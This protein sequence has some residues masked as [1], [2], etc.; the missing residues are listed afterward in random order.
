MPK[1]F[2]A[3][4]KNETRH[5]LLEKDREGLINDIERLIGLELIELSS[6]HR[7]SIIVDETRRDDIVRFYLD[8]AGSTKFYNIPREIIITLTQR[9]ETEIRPLIPHGYAIGI[10]GHLRKITTDTDFV[11]LL[12]PVFYRMPASGF[13]IDFNYNVNIG[14]NE[15]FLLNLANRTFYDRQAA[16]DNQIN[17]IYPEVD[18][19]NLPAVEKA[20]IPY[21]IFTE[22]VTNLTRPNYT[23]MKFELAR[24]APGG[25]ITFAVSCED[26]SG[27]ITSAVYF[28]GSL[29]RGYFL[30]DH[31]LI[32]PP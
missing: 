10:Y 29:Y 27:N 19:V 22:F 1:L 31:D 21:D 9:L 30:D 26:Q 12:E 3:G 20:F 2:Y 13:D 25:R 4:L 7:D 18:A 5:S 16:R 6:F 28:K 23:S 8:I 14:E 15:I 11:I 32:P 24:N 17:N